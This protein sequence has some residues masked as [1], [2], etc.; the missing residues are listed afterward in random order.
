MPCGGNC[1]VAYVWQW[2]TTV[3]RPIA[4]IKRRKGKHAPKQCALSSVL[5]CSLLQ[6]RTIRYEFHSFSRSIAMSTAREASALF[7]CLPSE[8]FSAGKCGTCQPFLCC[9]RIV[10]TAS[11]VVVI[12]VV[13]ILF[14]SYGLSHRLRFKCSARYGRRSSV[15]APMP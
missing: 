11:S 12:D 7:S 9:V 6:R 3:A 13:S 2:Q 8:S 10:F 5:S 1:Y 4:Q 14:R 15:C